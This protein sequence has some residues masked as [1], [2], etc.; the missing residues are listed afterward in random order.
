MLRARC[1]PAFSAL[2]V[3]A[4]VFVGAVHASAGAEHTGALTDVPL[5]GGLTAALAVVDDRVVGDRSQFLLE[6]IRR[7]YSTP[8]GPKTES[9]D[10]TLR[11][12]LVHLEKAARPA[13]SAPP[14]RAPTPT[15]ATGCTSAAVPGASSASASLGE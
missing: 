15:A 10:A 14:A 13:V 12:L 11:A 4:A 1:F 8:A 6:F 7:T 3:C 9:R 5:P 2:A